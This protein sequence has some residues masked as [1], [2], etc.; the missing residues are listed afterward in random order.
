MT[1]GSL[2][3]ARKDEMTSTQDTTAASRLHSS[4]DR[5]EEK[6]LFEIE[7]IAELPLPAI[8]F[9]SLYRRV[10]DDREMAVELLDMAAQRLEQEIR[11]MRWMVRVRDM[12]GVKRL[13]HRLRGMAGN[14]SAE[15]L[16]RAS[17][18]LELAAKAGD[19]AILPL[20]CQEFER[21]AC[22]FRAAVHARVRAF[23]SQGAL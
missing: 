18:R 5:L 17:E 14:L 6:V 22:D 16:C 21:A 9:E 11:D 23:V 13:A 19:A 20:R 2:T 8:E 3:H 15:P 1:Y 4:H 10:L 7:S 12:D